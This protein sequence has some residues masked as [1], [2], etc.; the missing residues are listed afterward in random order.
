M[1]GKGWLLLG[2]AFLAIGIIGLALLGSAQSLRVFQIARPPRRE[3]GFSKRAPTP[4]G[5]RLLIL[6]A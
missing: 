6:A 3:S 1:K 2:L 5:S 4:M